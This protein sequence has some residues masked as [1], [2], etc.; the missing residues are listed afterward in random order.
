MKRT[1]VLTI[2]A[3]IAA[4]AFLACAEGMYSD[5]P[6]PEALAKSRL[7][8]KSGEELVYNIYCKKIKVGKSVLTF[9]GDEVIDGREVYHITFTTEISMLKDTEEIY[10][11][12]DT[13]LPFRINR[14]IRR[15]GYFP[16]RIE[17][18]YDQEAYGIKIKK[19]GNLFTQNSCIVR[20]GPISNAILLTYFYR[21]K[22]DISKIDTYKAIL[23]T[24]DFNIVM[25]GTETLLT[26]FG[27]RAAYV[28]KGDPPKFT[29]WLCADEKRIPLKMESHTIVDYT[30]IL[31]TVN[32]YEE[33]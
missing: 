31:N 25:K 13:F 19:K 21:S 32:G 28:F 9:H 29:F 4:T 14:T 24:T 33:G 3:A 2:T 8:F 23:P 1:I 5:I 27:E 16:T 7:P 11:H 22:P 17:E 30:F 18:E 26:C 6:A 20:Q 12:K 15:G 10:A